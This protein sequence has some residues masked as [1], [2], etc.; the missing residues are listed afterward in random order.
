MKRLWSEKCIWLNFF[1]F[2]T[3]KRSDN[4][5]KKCESFAKVRIFFVP[6]KKVLS[7]GNKNKI[8]FILYFPHLIVPLHS[9]IK[10]VTIR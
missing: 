3:S 7:F 10:K 4:F 2:L 6:F 5:L 8:G 9:Q 1:N